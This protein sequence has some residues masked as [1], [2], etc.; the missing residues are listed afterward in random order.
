MTP[1]DMAIAYAN[2]VVGPKTLLTSDDWLMAYD[3]WFAGWDT[4]IKVKP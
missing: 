4:A 2:K 3:A 1:M